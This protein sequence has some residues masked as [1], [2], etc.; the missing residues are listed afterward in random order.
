MCVMMKAMKRL[1]SPVFVALL[2]LT[3]PV[4]GWNDAGHKAIT[5]IAYEHLTPAARQ[6]IDRL[7][8]K[9]PDYP[10]WIEG[11]PIEGRSR[12]A[13]LAPAV[14]PDTIRGDSRFHNDG[15]PA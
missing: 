8:A 4:Y 15:A 1:F 5:V 6:R 12:A 13:L 7:L 11:V 3:L 2:L 10:K 9:H 14:W